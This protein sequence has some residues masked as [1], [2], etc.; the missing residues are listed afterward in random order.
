MSAFGYTPAMSGRRKKT[1]ST[2]RYDERLIAARVDARRRAMNVEVK[3]MCAELGIE[4]W[5][6]S[7]KIRGDRSSF[8]ISE[9]SKI[10]DLLQAP[11][12][13][14]FV[15]EQIGQILELQATR[16]RRNQKKNPSTAAMDRPDK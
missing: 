9:L 14:P 16:T 11:T 1:V 5:D 10:A 8:S 6:W 3:Q 15:D 7:R 4:K 2:G 13:W 12:G